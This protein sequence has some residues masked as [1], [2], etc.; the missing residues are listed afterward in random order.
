MGGIKHKFHRYMGLTG[1]EIPTGDGPER[2]MSILNVPNLC[3]L[4]GKVID[5]YGTG[6]QGTATDWD[7]QRWAA[8]ERQEMHINCFQDWMAKQNG[9]QP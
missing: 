2:M 6:P 7:L 1:G 3:K 5:K 8:E 9:N 4:C